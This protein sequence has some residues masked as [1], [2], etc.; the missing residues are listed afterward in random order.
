[1]ATALTTSAETARGAIYQLSPEGPIQGR[2]LA[3]RIRQAA[4]GIEDIREAT[5]TLVVNVA[6]EEVFVSPQHITELQKRTKAELPPEVLDAMAEAPD[7]AV[8]LKAVQDTMEATAKDVEK[9]LDTTRVGGLEDGV[10]GQA[11]LGQEGS[12]VIDVTSAIDD[13]S[14]AGASAIDIRKLQDVVDHEAR[15]E[16]HAR[17]W[18]AQSVDVGADRELTIKDIVETDAMNRQESIEWVSREYKEIHEYTTSI[19][20]DEQIEAIAESG[21]LSQ[22]AHMAGAAQE[23]VAAAPEAAPK[24]FEPEPDI[25]KFPETPASETGSST[26]STGTQK[27]AAA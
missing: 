18:D 11:K 3:E 7:E 12:S 22:A 13:E 19:L 26:G 15:H 20:T 10:A 17:L 2:E 25:L 16:E 14:E 9:V 27:K 4:K 24:A 23:P 6:P 8:N 1:M 5:A 21:D